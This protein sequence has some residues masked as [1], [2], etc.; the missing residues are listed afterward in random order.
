M[1]LRRGVT[2]IEIL[3]AMVI[4]VA[5]AAVVYPTVA[6]QLRRGQATAL[7]NQLDNVRT[8]LSN[9][10]QNVLR[11]PSVLT[12]L[13]TQPVAGATDVCGVAIPAA[14]RA[15]WR[16]PYLNQNVAGNIYVGEDSVLNALGYQVT[17]APVANLRL[18]ALGVDTLT[19]AELEREFDGTTLNYG[20][21]TILWST[22]GGGTLT[23]Q[24]PIR[25]C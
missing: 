5:L 24:I 8:A 3:I 11:Y 25:G 7:G 17:V 23:F 22:A 14:N 21:G 4:V 1:S 20:A 6:G 18:F 10:R 16:G 12:Q 13:T 19:A 15:L 2:L 9:Y